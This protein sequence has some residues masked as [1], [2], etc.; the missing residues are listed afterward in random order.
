MK[1]KRKNSAENQHEDFG[2]TADELKGRQSVR[3][4]FRLPLQTI[5]LLS[6]AASQLGLKQK[7]LFDQLVED[8]SILDQVASES[9][10]FQQTMK[11]RRQKTFVLSRSSLASLEHIA[12]EHSMPRDMLVE[13]SIRRLMPVIS[14]EQAK[15]EKRVSMLKEME[16]FLKQGQNLLARAGKMLGNQDPVV[17]KIASFT[18]ACER[19]I[20]E[21]KELVEKGKLMD[22][23]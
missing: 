10:N 16:Q 11:D 6:I 1:R 22:R 5:E 7:S 17:E 19:N 3:A 20:E 13:V 4:T 15:Q 8:R 14:S 12:K 2:L 23:L 21:V 9:E 18:D